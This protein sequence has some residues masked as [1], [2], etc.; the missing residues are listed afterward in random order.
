MQTLKVQLKEAEE[1]RG[2]AEYERH[3]QDQQDILD[4]MYQSLEDFFN[5]K[6]EDS[7][8]ILKE[9]EALVQDN[10]PNIKETLAN[11]LVFDK[12]A[13][14]S[15][16]DTLNNILDNAINGVA[17]NLI[18]VDGD[19]QAV[20]ASVLNATESLEGYLAQ[21]ELDL[22]QKQQIYGWVE[23][24]DLQAQNFNTNLI[25]LTSAFNN[26]MSQLMNGID[27]DERMNEV[28]QSLT[29]VIENASSFVKQA[30]TLMTTQGALLQKVSEAS[31]VAG[32]GLDNIFDNN[33]MFKL[34]AAY[35][36]GQ[37]IADAIKSVYKLPTNATFN[38]AINLDNVTD[39]KSFIEE[40]KNNKQFEKLIQ[41]MTL[42]VMEGN[43]NSLKKYSV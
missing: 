1:Q 31:T 24:L 9:A 23:D 7:N 2:D 22:L 30:N 8:A 36:S 13:Q 38:L 41:S 29:P 12:A 20:S 11:S 4:R 17:Q 25:S 18:S 34:Y 6:M 42:G 43:S 39:Y 15:V 37:S 16:S 14:A 27:Q 35:T 33:N 19:V 10:L 40:C 21:H 26:Q 28:K 5:D 32:A 3:L